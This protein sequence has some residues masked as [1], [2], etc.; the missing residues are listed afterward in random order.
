MEHIIDRAAGACGGISKL[1][2]LMGRSPQVVS[3]WR[4]RGVPL[5]ECA[6]LEAASGQVVRRWDMRPDDWHLIWPELIG[7]DGAPA[8]PATAEAGSAA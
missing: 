4:A 2:A 1:A 5:N 6:S 7:A 3:N 8:V